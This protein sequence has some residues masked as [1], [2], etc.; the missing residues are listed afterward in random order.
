M[1]LQKYA[2]YYYRKLRMALETWPLGNVLSGKV[3]TSVLAATIKNNRESLKLIQNWFPIQLLEK[4]VFRYGVNEGLEKLLN[5]PLDDICTN[6][7][8]L[9]YF[10]NTMKEDLRYLELGVS[11]GKTFWQLINSSTRAE[12]WGFDIEE[13]NPVLKDR[14]H[15]VSRFEWQ[16]PRDSIKKS[17]SSI[18]RFAHPGTGNAVVYICADIFDPKAWEF[19]TDGNFNIILS[20]ALHSSEALDFEWEQMTLRRIFNP[21]ETLLMWDDLDGPMHSWFRSRQ[22]SIASHL[23]IA[24][25]NVRAA[26]MN[27]WLG[28]REVP[29]RLGFAIKC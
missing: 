21:N 3:D 12:C 28:S 17:K 2:F 9:A 19:L 26:F 25:N 24:E 15:E 16:G 10:A 20:D 5:L 6:A 13:I 8:I 11:V 22:A 23:S 29:H 14:L 1:K 27:G 7:D 4:S 18:S